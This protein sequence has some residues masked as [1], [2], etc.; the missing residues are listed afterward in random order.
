MNMNAPAPSQAPAQDRGASGAPFVP[1]LR[2]YQQWLEKR[3]GPVFR[4]YE[5]LR[6]WSVTDLDA[7]WQSMWDHAGMLSPTPHSAVLAEGR[8]PG[9]KWFPGAQ[10]NYARQVLRHVEPASAAGTPIATPISTG[11]RP[12]RMTSQSTSPPSAPSAIRIPI[13]L[14]RLA[15]A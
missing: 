12:S 14:V 7:F 13:S 2:L 4:D 9:A 15:T 6:H 10:V 1:R 3:G 5:A 11:I 8:M